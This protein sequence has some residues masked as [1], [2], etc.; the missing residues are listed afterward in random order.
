LEAEFDR[1]MLHQAEQ[2]VKA[3]VRAHTWAAFR[4]LA[5]EGIP[6]AEVAQRLG[7][8]VAAAFVARSKVQKM[9]QEEMRRLENSDANPEGASP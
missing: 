6:G 9:I 4:L 3:R 8:K 2:R 7:M 5:I 1:E